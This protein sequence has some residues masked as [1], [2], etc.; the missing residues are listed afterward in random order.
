MIGKHQ[1]KK[2]LKAVED[3]DALFLGNGVRA[4]ARKS[5]PLGYTAADLQQFLTL[6]Y[7]LFDDR[8]AKVVRVYDPFATERG[9]KVT[10]A[11][12]A[13]ALSQLIEQHT[14]QCA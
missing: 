10:V 6:L 2:A 4:I 3:A 8:E 14:Q 12:L 13:E 7:G 5:L 11:R 1:Q 9:R